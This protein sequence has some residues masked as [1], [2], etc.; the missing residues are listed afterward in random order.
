MHVFVHELSPQGL[1]ETGHSGYFPV[2][3]TLVIRGWEERDCPSI[4][5]PLVIHTPVTPK[6]EIK[7]QSTLFWKR[8]WKRQ[9]FLVGR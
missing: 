2:G 7:C 9:S 5:V 1:Q 6:K 3:G 4:F 8:Q